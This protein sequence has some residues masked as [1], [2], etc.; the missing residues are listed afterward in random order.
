MINS[1]IIPPL[2]YPLSDI[3]ILNTS[4]TNNDPTAIEPYS[5]EVAEGDLLTFNPGVHRAIVTLKDDYSC[6]CTLRNE[7]VEY[8]DHLE[9]CLKEPISEYCFYKKSKNLYFEITFEQMVAISNRDDVADVKFVYD[10]DRNIHLADER[11]IYTG[12]PKNRFGTVGKVLQ[13]R[14][15]SSASTREDYNTLQIPVSTENS[16]FR[17]VLSATLNFDLINT[18]C[19]SLSEYINVDAVNYGLYVHNHPFTKTQN[20]IT[21]K[22]KHKYINDGSNVDVILLDS[23]ID[24]THPEFLNDQGVSRVVLEDWTQYKDDNNNSIVNTQSPDFYTDYNGHG[25]F[26]ASL[27]G[28][29]NTGWAPGCKIYSIMC[30][31]GRSGIVFSLEQALKLV[32]AFIKKKKDQG[33]NRPTIIN[34]SW[35]YTNTNHWVKQPTLINYFPTF[36]ENRGTNALTTAILSV[37]TLVD[38]IIALGGVMVSAAGNANQRLP[39]TKDAATYSLLIATNNSGG[40][41]LAM[42]SQNT[43]FKENLINT[44]FINGLKDR[45]GSN[46]G[47]YEYLT[48]IG[49][50][51]N[52]T[53]PYESQRENPMIIVGDAHP[54]PTGKNT[55]CHPNYVINEN[56]GVINPGKNL[57]IKSNYS[58]YGPG[59][60][61]FA[62]GYHVIGALS[63]N[64]SNFSRYT[65][66]TDQYATNTGTSF[67]CPQVVGV[68]ANYLHDNT[69]ATP[70]DCKDWLYNNCL[71]GQIAEFDNTKTSI[72]KLHYFHG[73]DTQN[74]TSYETLAIQVTSNY[75]DE[76]YTRYGYNRVEILSS[77]STKDKNYI[78]FSGGF[79]S[80]F[81]NDEYV[82]LPLD[83]R[84]T[85]D[86]PFFG[87]TNE[88]AEKYSSAAGI[89]TTG[90]TN[91][92]SHNFNLLSIH[93][94]YIGSGLSGRLTD[95]R[96]LSYLTTPL[97][98]LPYYYYA[99]SAALGDYDCDISFLSSY[100]NLA[101]TK[102]DVFKK[103][104]NGLQ[105]FTTIDHPYNITK[106][107][108]LACNS[109]NWVSVNL[110][111][112][113][114]KKD[115]NTPFSNFIFK[116]PTGCSFIAPLNTTLRQP[117]PTANNFNYNPRAGNE[118]KGNKLILTDTTGLIFVYIISEQGFTHVQTISS[119][120]ESEDVLYINRNKDLF[121]MY[122]YGATL[123][124]NGEYLAVDT[125]NVTLCSYCTQ[126]PYLSGNSITIGYSND[127]QNKNSV[128]SL[129][130]IPLEND[131][132]PTLPGSTQL[133]KWSGTQYVYLSTIVPKG[134][135]KYIP[136]GSI[137]LPLIKAPVRDDGFEGLVSIDTIKNDYL[138]A[139]TSYNL[140][141]YT[142]FRSRFDENNNLLIFDADSITSKF[143]SVSTFDDGIM[144]I[145]ILRARG[146]TNQVEVYSIDNNT[147]SFVLSSDLRNIFSSRSLK[148]SYLFLSSFYMNQFLRIDLKDNAVLSG[149]LVYSDDPFQETYKSGSI[150][151]NHRIKKDNNRLYTTL[152]LPQLVTSTS[153]T[154]LNP[155]GT[156]VPI[157]TRHIVENIG[158]ISNYP[159][160]VKHKNY[161]TNNIVYNTLPV[162]LNSLRSTTSLPSFSAHGGNGSIIIYADEEE[163]Y[164]YPVY[165]SFDSTST[166][167]SSYTCKFKELSGDY[168][169]KK[170]WNP[171]QAQPL[172]CNSILGGEE[173]VFSDGR[174]ERPIRVD[175]IRTH[176]SG[177]KIAIDQGRGLVYF[178][179]PDANSPHGFKTF[180]IFHGFTDLYPFHFN[181]V[182]TENGLYTPIAK[183][184]DSIIIPNNSCTPIT[185]PTYAFFNT[186]DTITVAYQFHSNEP[187]AMPSPRSGIQGT[188]AIEL[189]KTTF[190]T[191][192]IDLDYEHG[193]TNITEDHV[194]FNQHIFLQG[195]NIYDSP[196]L[197]LQSYPRNYI[198]TTDEGNTIDYDGRTYNKVGVTPYPIT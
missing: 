123:S 142:N 181:S 129:T 173:V 143:I 161:D 6:S 139:Y 60:D 88:L 183:A 168:F 122:I 66:L 80:I 53:F 19:Q 186:E 16:S 138:S 2:G 67:S 151:G 170:Y 7:L 179:T 149:S 28:G 118:S 160:L 62:S 128:A 101:P 157:I 82:F 131:I 188:L 187:H 126:N 136:G 102:V 75:F 81:D 92:L 154:G 64:G 98:S 135:L 155:N 86:Q 65:R 10:I 69:A 190:V 52:T 107:G 175:F 99:P 40:T 15:I 49:S 116:T 162:D 132:I 17:F 189:F 196:N 57:F 41:V 76:A 83:H 31:D 184:L 185:I 85:F 45:L 11:E 32:K 178:L 18:Y 93:P 119:V 44:G 180:T 182:P 79:C 8:C 42:R 125:R 166:S 54:Q 192:K 112:E 114:R 51:P 127:V 23:G 134:H 87:L 12:I 159:W 111:G 103:T 146:G 78:N 9:D 120:V 48:K 25:T 104:H 165:L 110:L 47:L 74:I 105:Y 164:K 148:N 5:G 55:Y 24:A 43:K 195:H 171:Y 4:L 145:P 147:V 63:K 72:D 176:E 77:Y 193:E 158:D 115:P 59:V 94:D 37:N 21:K 194:K 13:E 90:N 35:G 61:C 73:T 46:S 106:D 33:I 97:G 1:Q 58:N 141:A 140:N 34:N 117:R 174:Q 39:L 109:Y 22:V 26:C 71:S 133:Y 91:E 172:P 163:R 124:N 95:S 108:N 89:N 96:W 27:I 20:D 137:D 177:K 14:I 150:F 50:C 84:Y 130:G 100:G 156:V 29:K 56:T 68:L 70:L 153:N 167:I 36:L 191:F 121:P 152:P 38:E 30:V 197:L 113:L 3:N 169:D 198:V 144:E